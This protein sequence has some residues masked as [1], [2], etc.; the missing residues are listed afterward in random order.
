MAFGKLKG[1]IEDLLG[2]KHAERDAQEENSHLERLQ[3]Q[4]ARFRKELRKGRNESRVF[5][6]LPSEE[7][8]YGDYEM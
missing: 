3:E 6:E 8:I 4:Y 1:R 2:R 7:E 5:F